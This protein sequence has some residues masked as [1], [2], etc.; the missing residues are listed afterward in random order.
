MAAC[1]TRTVIIQVS[2]LRLRLR[3][4]TD[5]ALEIEHSHERGY[6]LVLVK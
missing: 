5:G 6:R 4:E 2:S 3:A 1:D